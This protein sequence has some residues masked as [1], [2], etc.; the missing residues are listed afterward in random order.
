MKY[1]KPYQLFESFESY[2]DIIQYLKD[3]SL[4]LKDDGHS[5]YISKP[6]SNIIFT[7]IIKGYKYRTEKISQNKFNN[8]NLESISNVLEHMVSY[9]NDLGFDNIIMTRGEVKM[10]ILK[11]KKSFIRDKWGSLTKCY[12][13]EMVKE[14]I[15]KLETL[16][17]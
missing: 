10:K 9:M 5:V 11:W 15:T 16:L 17:N 2:K 6:I 3:V 13:N 12:W 14:E 1:L 8:Q 4:E 7:I